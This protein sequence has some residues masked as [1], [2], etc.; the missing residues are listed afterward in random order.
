[1]DTFYHFMIYPKYGYDTSNHDACL[2]PIYCILWL[3][4]EFFRLR[5]F[6]LFAKN[7]LVREE[8]VR[9]VS[10]PAGFATVFELATFCTFLR[11][12]GAVFAHMFARIKANK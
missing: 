11:K 5:D 8:N 3:C 9:K 10:L 12:I 2:K 7:L 1:M 4:I 6:R